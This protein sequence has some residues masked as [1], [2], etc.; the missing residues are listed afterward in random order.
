MEVRRVDLP[1]WAFRTS[2]K[3]T[4]GVKYLFHQG[5]WPDQRSRNPNHPSPSI[6]IHIYY[7][8]S[9]LPKGRS[10]TA[11]NLGCSSAEGRSSTAYSGTKAAVYQGLNR[12]GSFTLL[13]AP[14][15]LS[16]A[17]EQTLKDLKRSKRIPGAPKWRWGEWIWLTRP[18]GLYR[19]SPQGLNISS[20]RVFDQ[21]R[22]PEIQPPFAPIYIGPFN[23]PRRLLKGWHLFP[24]H[25]VCPSCEPCCF[26][27]GKASWV[28][29]AAVCRINNN[30]ELNNVILCWLRVPFARLKTTGSSASLCVTVFSM[31]TPWFFYERLNCNFEIYELD[32]SINW[33]YLYYSYKITSI[34]CY[35]Y[36]VYGSYVNSAVFCL[37]D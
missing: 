3:F 1:N 18:S 11:R 7:H 12:G 4:T 27:V 16:L 13:S 5:F 33:I 21:I 31:L 15:S 29:E 37:C 9:I 19:N 32:T 34:H 8:Q 36:T 10:F 17:S 22:D 23:R 26:E 35:R 30:V 6:Y 28:W 14:H 20:I 24:F 2:R 25:S